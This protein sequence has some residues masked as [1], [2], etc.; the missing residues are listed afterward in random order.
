[1][2]PSYLGLICGVLG[3]ALLLWPAADSIKPKPDPVVRDLP[4]QA[5]DTYEQLWRKLAQDAAAKLDSGELKTDRDVWDF[6]AKGQEPARKVAFEQLA[7]SEQDYFNSQ[8][9][10]SAAAHSKL[11]RSYAK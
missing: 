5:F 1:M 11:L 7:K 8:G 2:K 9:G 10:W 6:L 4:A 3:V